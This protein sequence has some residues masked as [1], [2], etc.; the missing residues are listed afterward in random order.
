VIDED[1]SLLLS[2]LSVVVVA[3]AAAVYLFFHLFL[4]FL[5]LLLCLPSARQLTV[6]AI[7]HIDSFFKQ[8]YHN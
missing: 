2:V 3:A 8:W 6:F 5:S 4:S 7:Y 1:F